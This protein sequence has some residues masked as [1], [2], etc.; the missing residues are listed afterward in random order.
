[1]TTVKENEIRKSKRQRVIVMALIRFGETPMGCTVRNLSEE[2]AV[3]DVRTGCI[4]DYFT[5]IAATQKR[6]IYSCKAVWRDRR[7]IGVAFH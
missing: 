4:P 5:L 3:L 7:R 2:G 6:K 1:M